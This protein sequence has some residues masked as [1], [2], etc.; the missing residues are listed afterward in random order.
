M[1]SYNNYTEY[2]SN[3]DRNKTPSVEEYLNKTIPYLRDIINNL[4]S[5]DK[6]KIQLIIANQ[7]CPYSFATDKKIELHKKIFE[8][9]DFCNVIMPSE[10][11]KI[12]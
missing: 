7:P 4:K 9:K 5:F 10:D 3:S 8:N 12:L 1:S 11:T 2:E 6:W